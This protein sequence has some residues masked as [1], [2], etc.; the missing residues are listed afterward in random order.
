MSA[1]IRPKPVPTKKGLLPALFA[2]AIGRHQK[3]PVRSE[4][5]EHYLDLFVD[6]NQVVR[7]D[8]PDWQVVYGRRGSGKTLL[9]GV[10]ADLTNRTVSD[11]RE[12]AVR[13]NMPDCIVSPIGAAVSDEERALG[14]FHEFLNRL[15]RQLFD[16]VDA[17]LGE[18]TFIDRLIG[19]RRSRIDKIERLALELLQLA[20]DGGSIAAFARTKATT[21]VVDEREDKRSLNGSLGVDISIKKQDAGLKASVGGS[22]NRSHKVT[23]H[24]ARERLPALK[25]AAVR[26]KVVEL[27][28]AMGLQRLTIVVDE[29]QTLDP[30]GS[31]AIQPR[32]AELLKRTFFGA[33]Q[34]S[35]KIATNRYQTLFSNRA[36]STRHC[37]LELGAELF[38]ATNLDFAILD[39]AELAKF[40]MRL[41]F[42]RLRFVE[43]K[44]AQFEEP[45]SEDPRDGFVLSIFKDS[46]AFLEMVRGAQGIPRDFLVL[47]NEVAQRYGYRVTPLWEAGVICE[48]IRELAVAGKIHNALTSQ[49]EADHLL[50][51][52]IR[53]TCT[54][55]GSRM[56]LVPKDGK[57]RVAAA[58]DELV[59]KRFLHDVPRERL[60][61]PLVDRYDAYIIDY[62]TWLEWRRVARPA[63]E[64]GAKEDTITGLAH[65]IEA[66][67]V[68]VSG[69]QRNDL[70]RCTNP[71][72]EQWFA[73]DV[74]LYVRRGICP[75]CCEDMKPIDDP[76]FRPG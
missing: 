64:R 54:S 40:Y 58:L 55:S 17:V 42:K 72:C 37:G 47:F 61:A 45:E 66:I 52:A 24:V 12:L 27:V 19:Q 59:E 22:R 34:L 14:F 32:F 67:C 35:I 49:S 23:E 33:K 57:E 39:E 36:E 76:E 44:L 8:T 41:I 16:K 38:E 51:K 1:A 71:N 60:P 29:W 3:L 10:L 21:V 75:H 5:H 48:T 30:T 20:E 63:S 7:L 4:Y 62:G 65:E 6:H 28:D 31:T 69:V 73:R 70:I 18:P 50:N 68:D 56:V 53:A 9:L 13:V 11:R 15:V 2:T 46:R 25:L 43:P 74:K 26:D